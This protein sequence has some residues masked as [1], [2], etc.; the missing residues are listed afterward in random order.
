MGHPNFYF[1]PRNLN[2]SLKSKSYDWII[3]LIFHVDHHRDSR[4]ENVKAKYNYDPEKY[5]VPTDVSLDVKNFKEFI[6][7]RRALLKER[8]MTIVQ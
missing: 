4:V 8:L 3:S 7:K 1:A 2:V 5:L 6:T